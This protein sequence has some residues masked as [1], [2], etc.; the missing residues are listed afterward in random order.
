MD[1]F[2]KL[3]LNSSLCCIDQDQ[4]VL[5]A[6]LQSL[7]FH[8]SFVLVHLCPFSLEYCIDQLLAA[9]LYRSPQ[10]LV[11]LEFQT[12]ILQLT[13]LF[14]HDQDRILLDQHELTFFVILKYDLTIFVLFRSDKLQPSVEH[15][16]Y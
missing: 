11:C 16:L 14:F 6:Y 13:V 12:S 10:H 15:S 9:L 2:L 1:S 8:E 5:Y 3:K 4:D 7:I